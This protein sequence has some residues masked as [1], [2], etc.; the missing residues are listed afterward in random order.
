MF[1][2]R[3]VFIMTLITSCQK[4]ITTC[5]CIKLE[6][7]FKCTKKKFFKSRIFKK[8]VFLKFIYFLLFF[9]DDFTCSWFWLN[10][11]RLVSSYLIIYMCKCLIIHPYWLRDLFI[12][13]TLCT[14]AS[15]K[16]FSLSIKTINFKKIFGLGVEEM[17][18]WD[19]LHEVVIFSA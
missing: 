3:L 6:D 12:F 10:D 19:L 7:F 13:V 18:E 4:R 14:R 9:I 2:W 8:S 1:S 5:N 15:L 17:S 11:L 16:A